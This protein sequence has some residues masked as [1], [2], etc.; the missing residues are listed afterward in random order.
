MKFKGQQL[1]GV[2]EKI[3]IIGR[4]KTGTTSIKECLKELGYIIG[5]Q[6][7]SELFID[8]Y[9]S[10]NFENIL[11]Y[12]DSAEVFQDAPF[13]WPN[14]YKHVFKKYP[15][16]KYILLERDSANEWFE[17]LV[18]FHR[19]IINNGSP[20]SAEDLKN[21]KYRRQGF[22]WQVAQ[23]VY[24]V[25]ENEIY[26]RDIYIKNYESYNEEV[27]EFFKNKENFLCIKLSDHNV[28]HKLATFLNRNS[29]DVQIP[30][31]NRSK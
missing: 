20:V 8:D 11:A 10:G 12:C 5:D 16:A 6:Q 2:D 23:V 21:F 18:R 4:N 31:L 26:D 27:K 9:A 28:S 19:K 17:S 3:F 1:L 29:K 14:T 15:K 25:K 22:L 24:G 13:S 7:T 30:H